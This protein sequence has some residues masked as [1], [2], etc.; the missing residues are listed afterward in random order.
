M[1]LR[2]EET[3]YKSVRRSGRA[4]GLTVNRMENEVES[5]WPDVIMRG[6]GN[7][8]AYAE[9]KIAKGPNA[10]V[11]VRPEQ[12]NWA[13]EHYGLNGIVHMLA[14]CELDRTVFWVVPALRIRHVSKNGCLGEEC[15]SMRHLPM[16]IQRWTGVYVNLQ[17]TNPAFV[18]ERSGLARAKSRV[19]ISRA[20]M[21][22]LRGAGI[23]RG[24][25]HRG[26]HHSESPWG[27]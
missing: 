12:I 22:I 11:E 2:D 21:S 23:R 18:A 24:R 5:G 9:L 14:L 27:D 19:L 20:A 6:E 8:H 17:Q 26:P 4:A 15:Y 10:W 13:E 16:V 25:N 7:Y 1:L 3:F